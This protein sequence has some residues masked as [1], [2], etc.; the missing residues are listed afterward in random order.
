M[1]NLKYK[2]T[3]IRASNKKKIIK[4]LFNDVSEKYNLMN[5]IMSFGLHRLWK[6]DMINCLKHEDPKV[7]LD[8][9]GGTGDISKLLS[10]ICKHSKILTYDISINM[11]LQ[12]KQ[13]FKYNKMV[14]FINGS[15]EELA[16]SDDSIDL[17]TLAFG[18]RNF[19]NIEKA[20]SECYRV[21]KFGKK[22]YCLEFSPSTNINLLPF[23]N[24]YSQ[25]VIPKIGKRVA[26]NEDAYRYLVESI[27]NFPHNIELKNIFKKYGFFCYSEKKYLGGI[28][29]L[30]VFYKI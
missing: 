16:I 2:K 6:R 22:I 26:R 11:M 13:K 25:K 23:Y 12:S 18:L 17:I 19:S 9:A 5:D 21:L 4:E 27:K 29:Y 15:A 30:N 10:N 24:F 3:Y 7:I 8:L 20:I 28:A 14:S 1:N